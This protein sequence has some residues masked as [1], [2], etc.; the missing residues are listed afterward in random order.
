MGNKSK[1]VN[2]IL[3]VLNILLLTFLILSMIY[4]IKVLSAIYWLIAPISMLTTL[5]LIKIWSGN[6]LSIDNKMSKLILE[7]FYN[8]TTCVSIFYA[9]TYFLIMFIDHITNQALENDIVKILFFVVTASCELLTIY[10]IN[11][12]K[13]NTQ[14]LI[15]KNIRKKQ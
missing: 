15:E 8:I 2:I 4:D 7:P 1:L 11:K 14:K 13:K 10:S 6:G 5:Y 12:T 3:V 9:L